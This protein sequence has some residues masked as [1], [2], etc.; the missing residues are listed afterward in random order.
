MARHQILEGVGDI[1][2]VSMILILIAWHIE[3]INTL[4]LALTLT[5]QLHHFPDMLV[6]VLHILVVLYM[7]LTV[8][9]INNTVV[10]HRQVKYVSLWLACTI[11]SAD[12]HNHPSFYE[13]KTK[14]ITTDSYITTIQ[15]CMGVLKSTNPAMFSMSLLFPTWSLFSMFSPSLPPSSCPLEYQQW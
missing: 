10:N 15:Q 1:D 3:T 12:I 14:L 5:A 11:G 6:V 4:V 7:K 9:W 2:G 8:E 13:N